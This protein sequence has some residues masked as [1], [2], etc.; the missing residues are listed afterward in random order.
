M[1]R[2]ATV[3]LTR[4]SSN[5]ESALRRH[6]TLSVMKSTIVT[7]GKRLNRMRWNR[8]TAHSA[9]QVTVLV[10]GRLFPLE[11]FLVVMEEVVHEIIVS[12]PAAGTFD[13]ITV[14]HMKKMPNNDITDKTGRFENES[15]TAGLEKLEGITVENIKPLMD[16]LIFPDGHVVIELVPGHL[17]TLGCATG[18]PSF[19]M[20][21]EGNQGLRVAAS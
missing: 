2:L 18:H 4:A 6:Q 20:F 10:Q 14:E 7:L 16:R 8:H 11:G 12:I 21:A 13:N 5:M 9:S 19:V 17:P 3:R 15:D 1:M